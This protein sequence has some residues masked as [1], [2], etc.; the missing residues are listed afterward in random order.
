M[1]RACCET[2]P[3]DQYTSNRSGLS[4]T[5]LFQ[6]VENDHALVQ[7]PG[8]FVVVQFDRGDESLWREL[9]QV[10]RFLVR[11][12][13]IYMLDQSSRDP[14][15]DRA[16]YN[17]ALN[18]SGSTSSEFVHATDLVRNVEIFERNPDALD[19]RTEARS[20]QRDVLGVGVR[21]DRL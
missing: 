17:T 4:R 3:R 13:F 18:V 2:G 8:G 7:S 5:Q 10:Q 14:V 20:E 16:H 15:T 11:I 6:E 12:D 9:E 1:S 21:F 19:E